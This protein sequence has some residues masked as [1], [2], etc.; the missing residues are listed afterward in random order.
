MALRM[1]SQINT[2]LKTLDIKV[3]I[4]QAP[5]AGASTLELAAIVTKKGGLGSIPLGSHSENPEA[6]ETQ[7]LKFQELV[8]DENLKR[9]VNLNFFTHDVPIHD[10]T[11]HSQWVQK[12]HNYYQKEN[13][14]ISSKAKGLSVPYPTFK[15]IET[16]S[17]PV[18]QILLKL[19]PKV[20]SFHFGL[21]NLQVLQTLQQSGINVFIS[22][23]NLKEFKQVVEAGVDGVILQSWEA[24]GHRGN[25]I[26]N[27]PNDDKLDTEGLVK[28]IV[29]YIDSNLSESDKIP[30][31]V[32]AG[33]L[34]NGESISKVLDY[35]I[36]GVQLGTVW[37]QTSQ[38]TTSPI[39]KD[40]LTKSNPAPKTIMSPAISGRNL[41]TIETDYLKELTSS[42]THTIPDYPLPYSIFKTLGGDAKNSGCKT[43]YS[44]FLAGSNYH[45]SRRNTNDAGEI[46]DQIVSEL[47]VKG[48]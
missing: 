2:F 5:M 31:L 35:G 11:K 22:V 13:I 7:L 44:A 45:L 42:P 14:E 1:K 32:A 40:L 16:D 25:F 12:I 6:V 23:T 41:R 9:N 39:H 27:D 33:G 36:A 18:I 26:A 46:F 4:I 48:Y 20:I 8:Q 43:S 17:H 29:G 47:K 19:K 3:P 24:G 37:L 28:E 38:A 30:F 21:P 34:Y 15:S 10:E